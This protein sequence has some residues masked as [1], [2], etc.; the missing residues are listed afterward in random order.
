VPSRVST[1]SGVVSSAG[2]AVVIF[3]FGVDCDCAAVDP[4]MNMRKV[5]ETIVRNLVFIG[6]SV[7]RQ[8][9]YCTATVTLGIFPVKRD[10]R[11]APMASWAAVGTT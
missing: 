7:R 5:V 10:R 3:I 11:S 1:L 8:P 2:I 4:I 6:I 9:A